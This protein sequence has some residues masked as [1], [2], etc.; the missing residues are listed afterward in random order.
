MSY[1][2]TI[3]DAVVTAIEG[4]ASPPAAVVLRKTDNL[5]KTDADFPLVVVTIAKEMSL[6]LQAFGDANSLGSVVRAYQI[7]VT[8]YRRTAAE[9]QTDVDVLPSLTLAIEQLLNRGT[10]AGASTVCNT[11]LV[12]FSPFE[13]AAA[14]SGFEVSRCQVVFHSAEARN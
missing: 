5:L 9:V 4:L 2:K 6:A 1:A 13:D 12:P 11:E 7:G 14:K 8:V 3:A 10:L